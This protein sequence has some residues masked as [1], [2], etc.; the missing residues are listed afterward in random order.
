MTKYLHVKRVK[1]GVCSV[2]GAGQH[3]AEAAWRVCAARFQ[4][5]ADAEQGRVAAQ[6]HMRANGVEIFVGRQPHAET[7]NSRKFSGFDA[8]VGSSGRFGRL[9]VP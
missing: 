5:G 6:A 9:R 8:F 3:S 1:G 7:A 2:R 4:F